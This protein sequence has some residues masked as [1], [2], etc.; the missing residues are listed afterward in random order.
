MG[1]R[2]ACLFFGRNSA[3]SSELSAK[4]RNLATFSSSFRQE[5]DVILVDLRPE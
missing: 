1:R 4:R 5:V 3:M 2:S